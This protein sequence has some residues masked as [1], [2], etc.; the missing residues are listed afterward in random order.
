MLRCQHGSP[1]LSPS[2]HSSLSSTVP[3][4][5]SKLYPVSARSILVWLPSSFFSIRLVSVHL[6]HPYSCIDTTAAWKKTAFYFH[7]W[8]SDYCLH[9]YYNIHNVSADVFPG[10]LVFALIPLTI[11]GFK[12]KGFLYCY[13]PAVRIEPATY[14]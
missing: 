1:W 4:R 8:F 5:S 7:S 2:R 6:V 9:L 14:W 12:N 3:W 11:T 10:L 13:L